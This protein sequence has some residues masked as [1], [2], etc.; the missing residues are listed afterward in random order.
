[1][2]DNRDEY[3]RGGFYAFMFSMA[4]CFAFMFYLVV[5]H[6]GVN[7]DEKVVDPHAKGADGEVVEQ[8]NMAK[9]AEPWVATPEVVTYGQKVFQTNCSMCH[10]NEGKGDGPAGMGLNPRPRNLVEGKWTQGGNLTDHFKV[11]TNGIT[12]TS[13]AGYKH[14]KVGDRWALVHYVESITSNKSKEDAAKV[15]EFAKTAQ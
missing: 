2:S 3:N 9:V 7:L 13:M 5:I 4:F 15:A 6:P 11:V 12:G 1:M 10:G 14:F 8:F